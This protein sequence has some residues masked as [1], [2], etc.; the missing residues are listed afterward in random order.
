MEKVRLRLKILY[1]RAGKPKYERLGGGE[2]AENLGMCRRSRVE[3]S[4]ETMN[5][6]D[7]ISAAAS[8]ATALGIFVAGWQ[9][10][11]GKRQAVLAFE[12]DLT[13]QYREIIQRIPIRALLDE[14][15]EPSDEVLA[16]VY[17]Y[18]DLCNEQIFLRQSNRVTEATWDSWRQGMKSNFAREPFRGA[19]VEIKEK[20]RKDFEELRYLEQRNFE[21]DPRSWSSLLPTEITP[22]NDA[23]RIRT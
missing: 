19:W 23:S 7:I 1:S 2:V 20:A 12:D 3:L 18:V 11:L 4:H 21:G 22:H 16:A 8:T 9:L 5:T 10:Y 17:Q 6:L 15:P 13:R 14:N